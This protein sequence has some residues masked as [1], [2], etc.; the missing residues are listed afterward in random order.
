VPGS[1]P[2][3]VGTCASLESGY[4]SMLS[5][6]YAQAGDLESVKLDVGFVYQGRILHFAGKNY[7]NSRGFVVHSRDG[8]GSIA[9]IELAIPEALVRRM[10]HLNLFAVVKGTGPGA[11][12]PQA[13]VMP[14]VDFSGVTVMVETHSAIYTNSGGGHPTGVVYRPL[15]NDDQIPATW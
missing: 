12:P 15:A 2:I 10:G 9:V 14:L 11:P 5:A 7:G 1:A 13:S 8:L 6:V 4:V 3:E